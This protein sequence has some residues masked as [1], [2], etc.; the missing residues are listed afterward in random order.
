MIRSYYIVTNQKV[1]QVLKG[2]KYF[3]TNLGMAITMEKNGER[4]VSDKDQFAASYNYQYKT[5]IYAQGNIGNI[6]FYLDY[7]INDDK[8]AAYYEL[9]EFL[10]DYDKNFILEKGVDSYIG[11]ILKS[12]DDKYQE[13][14][15]EK[16][17]KLEK[18]EE[19]IGNAE[20]LTKNPGSVRYEDIKSYIQKRKI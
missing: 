3:R 1:I 20:M 9:E 12:V 18:R 15:Q 10:F 2:S 4:I 5:S 19:K 7:G 11:F 16:K 6:K 17:D 14:M 13:M 8:I